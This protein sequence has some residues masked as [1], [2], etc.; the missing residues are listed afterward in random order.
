MLFATFF[1]LSQRPQRVSAARF[2]LGNAVFAF[3]A[4]FQVTAPELSLDLKRE[5]RWHWFWSMHVPVVWVRGILSI[6]LSCN[7]AARCG[8]PQWQ[9]VSQMF[10]SQTYLFRRFERKRERSM[11]QWSMQINQIVWNK[12][13]RLLQSCYMISYH[14]SLKICVY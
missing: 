9:V 4:S 13:W 14:S 8:L 6:Q 3:P 5:F 2:A 10:G 7:H 11:K 12:H 1:A